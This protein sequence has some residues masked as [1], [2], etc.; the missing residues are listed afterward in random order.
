M[1]FTAG[2]GTKDDG[3][4]D[5]GLGPQQP[6]QHAEIA[7][8]EPDVLGL[9]GRKR[10]PPAPDRDGMDRAIGDR[11]AQGALTGADGLSELCQRRVP[12]TESIA[13]VCPIIFNSQSAHPGADTLPFGDRLAA[14]PI[15]GL[16]S[17][18]LPHRSAAPSGKLPQRHNQQFDPRDR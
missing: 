13:L 7:P 2:E 16:R 6:P 5:V 18:A 10:R 9:L 12:R 1:L 15:S 3:Q 11:A 4:R 8:M 14:V 17:G